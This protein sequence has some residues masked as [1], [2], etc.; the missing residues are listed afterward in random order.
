MQVK[1]SRKD[2]NNHYEYHQK[3]VTCM[4][5][6]SCLYHLVNEL[7]CSKW[8]CGGGGTNRYGNW[9][10]SK[11]QYIENH[12]LPLDFLF[13]GFLQKKLPLQRRCVSKTLEGKNFSFSLS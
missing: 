8:F 3:A 13:A 12:L 6:I 4:L 5:D 7:I 10:G 2:S 11:I 9:I 1:K